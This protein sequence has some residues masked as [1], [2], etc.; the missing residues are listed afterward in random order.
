MRENSEIRL[1]KRTDFTSNIH[2]KFDHTF[3]RMASKV[4]GMTK[5][6]ISNKIFHSSN[7]E[8]AEK[9]M[10]GASTD[11]EDILNLCNYYNID[12][13]QFLLL[14]DGRHPRLDVR[15]AVATEQEREVTIEPE[16]DGQ[17]TESVETAG[18]VI[19]PEVRM[20]NDSN[21]EQLLKMLND[22]NGKIVS[23]YERIV[24]LTAKNERMKRVVRRY[25]QEA[26]G[27]AIVADESNAMN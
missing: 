13:C 4:I 20:I 8:R 6:E 16:Q 27:M 3:F 1:P 11:M 18:N 23:L 22:A 5:N 14:P 21:V 26:D 25:E 2:L 19:T 12:I 17:Q 24:E 10:A 9:V 15:S 7:S